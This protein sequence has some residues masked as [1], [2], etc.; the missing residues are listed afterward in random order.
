MSI[1]RIEINNFLVFKDNFS[2]DL[3]PGVNVLIGENGTGKTTLM[4]LLY[5][6]NTWKTEFNINFDSIGINPAIMPGFFFS[7]FQNLI[8]IPNGNSFESEIKYFNYAITKEPCFII[9]YSKNLMS[10]V[11]GGNF[12]NIIANPLSCQKYV[13]FFREFLDSLADSVFIPEKDLLSIAKGLPES[14]E[15]GQTDFN[16]CDIDII[17]RA[18]VPANSPEQQLFKEICAI[19]GGK[20]LID[21][22][23]FKIERPELDWP[24]PFSMEA[25]GFR[26]FGLIAMLIRN[27]QIKPGSVLFWDE[28]ENSL[29]PELLPMLVDIL[30][31]ISRNGVQIFVATQSEILA[32]YFSVNKIK[33]DCVM[34]HTLYKDQKLIKID[35]ND[36][37]DLLNPNSLT[38]ERIKLYEKKLDE[39]L[40]DA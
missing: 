8:K 28:P 1:N 11:F 39:G 6:V 13:N 5:S 21:G 23:S 18:R 16:K 17:K 33:T 19:I 38:D 20:P 4:K 34:F 40:G 29:N 37:F 25:S 14:Y 10:A 12:E 2:A 36:R 26:K 22:E 9:K 24:I 7:T 15:Y 32:S 30:L 35:S 31:K 3:F 27:E